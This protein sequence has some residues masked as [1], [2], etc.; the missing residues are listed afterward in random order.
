M[1]KSVQ[2]WLFSRSKNLICKIVSIT[3]NLLDHPVRSCQQIG[4]NRQADLL[5]RFQIDDELRFHRLLHREIGGFG[6]FEDFG[7]IRGDTAV[8]IE[9][10]T[11]AVKVFWV[12]AETVWFGLTS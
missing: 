9:S 7:N 10:L 2:S 3:T 8:T 1:E 12:P 4:R 5:R 6:T 11:G